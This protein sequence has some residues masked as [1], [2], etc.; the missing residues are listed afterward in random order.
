MTP[1]RLWTRHDDQFLRRNAGIKYCGEIA[2][3]LGRSKESVYHRANTLGV[4]LARKPKPK[5]QKKMPEN[6]S[7]LMQR[8]ADEARERRAGWPT[9]ERGRCWHKLLRGRLYNA[10]ATW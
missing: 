2:R 9:L 10:S 5:P 7:A 3:E 4:R 1:P 6:F 8:C